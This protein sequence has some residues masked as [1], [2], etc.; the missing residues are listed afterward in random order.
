MA[1]KEII[2]VLCSGRGTNLQSIIAAVESGQIPAPIGVVL[3]DKPDV[4]A[5]E[6]AEK[7]GIPNFC[8]NRKEC[9][10][11]QEFEEKL[12]EKLREHGVTLVVLAGF[13]RILSPYFVRAFKGR[14]LNIHPA[15]L[16]SFPGAHAHRDVLEY[17][18]KVSGVTVHFV[19]E[20]MDSGPIILQA[21]VPVEDDDTE[22]TLAA[23]VLVEEHK[24]YPRAIE[25]Y[26]K[27][28]L[29]VE[30]RMVRILK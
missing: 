6:R 13:M 14:I 15:L 2:G 4:M 10:D 26:L 24:I 19:D 29:K 9:S 5:L 22:D 8:V 17:G 16:P 27:N 11:K 25:L 23:R 21:A 7:A 12:V 28:K 20:G 30:G 3:T 1:D 18:V